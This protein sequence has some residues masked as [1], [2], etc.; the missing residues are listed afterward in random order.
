MTV[1]VAAKFTY[2]DVVV[3]LT[4]A[5]FAVVNAKKGLAGAL[6]RFMPTLFGV[7]LSWKGSSTVIKYVRGTFIFPLITEKIGDS[8]NLEN[9]LPDMTMSAQNDII[10]EMNVPD[11]I[12]QALVNNNNSVVYSIFNVESLKEYIASF[13]GNILVSVAVVI[14]LYFVG[15]IVG[16]LILKVLNIANDL[17]VIGLFSRAG[18]FVVGLLKGVC[19][20]WIV[21]IVVTFFCCKPW[22][23]DFM[24]TLEYSFA[25]GWFYKNNILLYV[26]LQIM[27]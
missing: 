19:V 5:V 23:Q 27:A 3:F 20:V 16:K 15:L 22:A 14:I 21:A 4:I 25:A 2:L 6:L 18:G 11:I 10:A 1:D 7:I 17:P 26:V 9:V 12:K 8:L 13:L 24:S